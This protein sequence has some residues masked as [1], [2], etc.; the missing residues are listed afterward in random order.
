MNNYENRIFSEL[1]DSVTQKE[2]YKE[3]D[4]NNLN[5]NSV[6]E[7]IDLYQGIIRLQLLYSGKIIMIDAQYYDGLYFHLINEN[8]LRDFFT[9]A[10]TYNLLEIKRRENPI[11]DMLFT[12]FLYS[13]IL[14]DALVKELYDAGKVLEDRLDFLRADLKNNALSPLDFYHKAMK[15]IGVNNILFENHAEKLKFLE[16][17]SRQ[18]PNVFS[19]W[20]RDEGCMS[21]ITP[22]GQIY[23]NFPSV[24][25]EKKEDFI[26]AA[27]RA[28]FNEKT[29]HTL[30]IDYPKRSLVK[31][32]AI[33]INTPAAYKFYN[34]FNRYYQAGMGAQH[35]CN[36]CDIRSEK[37][38]L[39]HK[40]GKEKL[41]VKNLV[42]FSVFNSLQKYSWHDFLLAYEN[43]TISR[44][45]QILMREI[46]RW[47]NHEVTDDSP[48]KHA[49]NNMNTIIF[50]VFNGSYPKQ[51]LKTEIDTSSFSPA[52]PE[53]PD[54]Y[55]MSIH[56]GFVGFIYSRLGLDRFN[57]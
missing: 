57:N 7:M 39:F 32:D 2:I 41:T 25:S 35:L 31:A 8:E 6:K 53:T 49:L 36:I 42:D 26:K 14:D 46:N 45:R 22:D 10:N 4:Q 47:V 11:P 9:I 55:I 54:M 37:G 29:I 17:L 20:K 48:L 16:A 24:M 51:N 13:S 18:F 50:N 15:K 43:P 52:S 40:T 27:K 21:F 34:T 23:K 38:I 56:N 12:Q 33:S 19:L 1:H 30:N 28:G 44:A 3:I 5:Q